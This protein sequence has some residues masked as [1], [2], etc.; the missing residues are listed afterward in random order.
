MVLADHG[1]PDQALRQCTI[2]FKDFFARRPEAK[3]RYWREDLAGARG[4]TPPGI[5][6]A[7]G[8]RVPDL[9]EFWHVG[10]E[11]PEGHRYRTFMPENIWVED[12]EGFR[13]TLLE[14]FEAFDHLGRTLLR[15]LARWLGLPPDVL[16]G[17]VAEGNSILRILHYPPVRPGAEGVRAAAHGDINVLT[18]LLGADEGGLEI[19]GPDGTWWSVDPPPGSLVVNVGDMLERLTNHRLPSALH[20]VVNPSGERANRDRYSMPFFL[21]FNPDFLVSTL[22][23]CIDDA[24]PDRYPVSLTADELLKSRLEE[25]GLAAPRPRAAS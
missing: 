13:D 11:L 19:R 1:L 17:A 6:T 24:H 4:Y 21:H 20:R 16:D 8:Q 3:R 7:K 5:E 23:T 22:P 12:I 14:A 9:K 18:L 2:Y 25:I 10:R 15:S